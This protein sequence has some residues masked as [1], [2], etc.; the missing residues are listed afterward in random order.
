MYFLDGHR[1]KYC[2]GYHNKVKLGMKSK[3][4]LY[5][6]DNI[7]AGKFFVVSLPNNST[8]LVY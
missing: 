7:I 1:F 2:H 6:R 4:V 3:F 8:N 5:D